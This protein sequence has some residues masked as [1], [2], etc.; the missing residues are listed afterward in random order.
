[1]AS[2]SV[3]LPSQPTQATCSSLLQALLK[4]LLYARGHIPHLYD[5]LLQ[6]TLEEQEQAL[7]RQQ[8]QAAAGRKRPRRPKK[9][10]KRRLQVHAVSLAVL[11]LAGTGLH[12]HRL[13]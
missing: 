5:Q 3:Q 10:D 8:Q 6:Q 4:H 12:P 1:M 11:A 13:P 9:S 2:L 7:E